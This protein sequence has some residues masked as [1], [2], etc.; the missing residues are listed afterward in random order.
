MNFYGVTPA[1]QAN[2]NMHPTTNTIISEP[3]QYLPNNLEHQIFIRQSQLI[4]Q[5]K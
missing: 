5:W 4:L 3:N 1:D 2:S